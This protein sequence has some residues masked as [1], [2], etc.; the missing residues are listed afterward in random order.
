MVF[1]VGMFHG[2]KTSPVFR[3]L[4]AHV[5]GR[6]LKNPLVRDIGVG[7]S[8]EDRHLTNELAI[9]IEAAVPYDASRIAPEQR[10]PERNAGI[11]VSIIDPPVPEPVL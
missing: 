4:S 7:F 9:I 11:P 8:I 3:F 5:I 6:L 1:T 10:L 2:N